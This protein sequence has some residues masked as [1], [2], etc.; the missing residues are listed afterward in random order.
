MKSLHGKFHKPDED[1]E[2][3]RQIEHKDERIIVDKID[4]WVSDHCRYCKSHQEKDQ[5]PLFVF[6]FEQECTGNKQKEHY[7]EPNIFVP[8]LIEDRA[9]YGEIIDHGYGVNAR[10]KTSGII[11]KQIVI[12][13]G[14]KHI[15]N[16]VV[17]RKIQDHGNRSQNCSQ[18]EQRYERK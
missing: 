8:K 3:K 18:K 16:C 17:D 10:F 9:R 13:I 12:E 5:S 11:K 4:P 2:R 14:G 7:S 1:E 15:A 6:A